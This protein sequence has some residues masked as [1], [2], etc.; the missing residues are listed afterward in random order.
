[1]TPIALLAQ[2]GD[3]SW[4]GFLAEHRAELMART[5]EHLV[6]LT[7]VPVAAAVVIGVPA[8]VVVARFVSLRKPL[9]GL[10]SV[11][12]TIPSLALL[13]LLQIVAGIGLWPAIIAL[14]AYALLPIIRNTYTGITGVAGEVLEAGRALG[15]TRNQRLWWI[16]LPLALPVIVAGIRT[17]AVIDVGIATL[18]TLIG[19]GGLGDFIITGLELARTE[20]ILLGVIPA[21]ALALATDGVIGLIERLL[22][23]RSHT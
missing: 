12:Q 1:M 15:L 7:L 16:E 5:F 23:Q 19:A 17:A 13:A 14:T 22:A 4:L 2:A 8:G 11:I 18:A 9:L 21:A 6:Y 20:L 3:A 10:A